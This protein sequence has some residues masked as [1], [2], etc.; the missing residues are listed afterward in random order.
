MCIFAKPPLAGLAKTRL[1]KDIG[2]DAAARVAKAFVLDTWNAVASIPWADPVLACSE[3]NAELRQMVQGSGEFWLQGA[4][5]LGARLHRILT[6]AT[7]QGAPVI[8]IG[9]DTPGLP[10]DRMEK[11]HALVHQAGAVIGPADDGGFYLLGLQ[12]V[13]PTLFDDVSWGTSS[14]FAET[15][16]R[17]AASGLQAPHLLPWFDVDHGEDLLRLQCLLQSGTI[18]APATWAALLELQ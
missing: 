17:L 1:A 7:A 6:R 12:R 2:T 16:A 5:D 18:K 10:V 3:E 14:V 8:A 11:A 4:G 13:P 9:A 15:T